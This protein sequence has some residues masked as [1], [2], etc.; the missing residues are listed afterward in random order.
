[1]NRKGENV[2]SAPTSMGRT[3]AQQRAEGVMI[4]DK[5][6]TSQDHPSVQE[7]TDTTTDMEETHQREEPQPEKWDST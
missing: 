7:P 5:T 4:V 2:D 1:M 3:D 6:G